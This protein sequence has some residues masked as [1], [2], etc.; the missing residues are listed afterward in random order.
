MRRWLIPCIAAAFLAGAPVSAADAEDGDDAVIAMVNG[1]PVTAADFDRECRRAQREPD[2]GLNDF[3]SQVI[4]E[5][6]LETLLYQEAL[7]QEL[8]RDPKIRKMMVNTLLKQDVYSTISTSD[9]SEEQ[10]RDYFDAHPEEFVVPEKVQIKRILI[11]VTE[12]RGDNEARALAAN[13]QAQAA[14]DPSR[15]KELAMAHSDGPYARRGGDLGFVSGEGK[16]GVE[17]AVV[18]VAFGLGT[19]QVSAVFETD[20]GFNVVYVPNRRERVERT[21]EQMRGSVLRKV[22]SVRYLELYEAFVA[23]LSQGAAILRDE[24]A[25]EQLVPP[26]PAPGPPPVLPTAE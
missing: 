25:I 8:D 5:L 12:L 9:I 23:D 26:P 7:R 4:D 6:I 21:F 20:Q 19:G 24:D 1:M 2:Q 22:K 18:T 3:R 10:L 15:F 16:P 17:Q 11:G 13:L 14:V